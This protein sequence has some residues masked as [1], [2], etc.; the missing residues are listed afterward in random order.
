MTMMPP[1]F[2]VI[3]GAFVALCCVNFLGAI[4]VGRLLKESVEAF[5]WYSHGTFEWGVF[6]RVW[7]LHA[8]DAAAVALMLAAF[9]GAGGAALALLPVR[10][11]R[12]LGA[13][14]GIG[15]G[16]GGL[17]A[18]G[19]GLCGV[20]YASVAVAVL[21]AGAVLAAVRERDAI[22]S[23][24]IQRPRSIEGWFLFAA[25][26]LMAAVCLAM[27]FGPEGGWDALYYH[28]RLPKLYAM[29]HKV[30]FVTYLFPSH[31]PQG[32]EMLF[33]LGWLLGGEGAAKLVNFAFWPLCA[34]A[35]LRLGRRIFDDGE[36][37]QR[38]WRRSPNAKAISG[39]GTVLA[40]TMPIVGTLASENYID[41]GLT[42]Y[43]VL[44][45][46]SLLDGGM[47]TAG[48]LLGV[49]LGAKYTAVFGLV[50]A[51][52]ALHAAG[53]RRSIRPA[54]IAAILPILPW[55]VKNWVFT[56]DPTAPFLSRILS[57]L[58]WAGG[59]SQE[60]LRAVHGLLPR[61]VFGALGG[62]LSAPWIMLK[63][64]MFAVYNP[65]VLGLLPI[66]LLR[67]PGRKE[68][69]VKVFFLAFAGCVLLIAPDGRYLQPAVFPFCLLVAAAAA[70]FET[71]GAIVRP[72][73]VGLLVASISGSAVYHLLDMHRILPGTFSVALGLEDRTAF[74][75]RMRDPIG[76]W[77]ATEF[78]NA[79]TEPAERV[80]VIADIKAYW[81][82]REAIYDCDAPDARRWLYLVAGRMRT[83][84][85]YARQFRQWNVR[86]I[87][88]L[89]TK[90]GKLVKDEDWYGG[91]GAGWA[92]FWNRR[93]RPGAQFLECAVYMLDPQGV[94]APKPDLPGPQ[95]AILVAMDKLPTFE[96]KR[97]A[98]R[99]AVKSGMESAHLDAVFGAWAAN[100]GDAKEAIRALTRALALAPVHQQAWYWLSAA[101]LRAG[102]LRDAA[103]SF[104]S[105]VGVNPRYPLRTDLERAIAGAI[106]SAR[107]GKPVQ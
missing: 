24:R 103:R 48:L 66:L 90:A 81:L 1:L 92:A 19:L 69:F 49:A 52:A 80:A 99:L 68:S 85:D 58:A 83:E 91:R 51:V 40:L 89:R 93:A 82:D 88:Y 9:A 104:E 74:H 57:P 25:M 7:A 44:A 87:L 38:S 31:Y 42:F 94:A 4:G 8:R 55:L 53:R 30:Y 35:M 54:A 39:L 98:F 79:A 15:C 21:A 70:R 16:L 76:Y 107:K 60:P 26:G 37:R 43:L 32:I 71:A 78:V 20:L 64:D 106:N 50:A 45:L 3:L 18:L 17:A 23:V 96:D 67:F 101:Y 2:T 12:N 86:T 59:I 56:G 73:V 22:K 28:L 63:R 27:A 72:A 47:V 34:A 33:T 5:K 65:V 62:A 14:L 97:A 6:G 11:E 61:S 84:E 95:E 77:Q 105:G 100:A 36:H 41:L 29:R 13:K 102:K 46:A 75:R 10:R